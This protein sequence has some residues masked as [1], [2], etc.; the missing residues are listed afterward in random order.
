MI[1]DNRCSFGE[2]DQ[3]MSEGHF[4]IF[5][6]VLDKDGFER[7]F[8]NQ[9]P[10]KQAPTIPFIYK[11]ESLQIPDRAQAILS[12]IQY[13]PFGSFLL[14]LLKKNQNGKSH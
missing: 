13:V 9:V 10:E 5:R 14:I 2:F 8:N 6:I 7:L 12:S 4:I 1:Q 11:R 3:I